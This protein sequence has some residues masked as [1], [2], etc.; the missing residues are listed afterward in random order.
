MSK[1]CDE[2]SSHHYLWP[3]SAYKEDQKEVRSTEKSPCPHEAPLGLDPRR[4]GTSSVPY[5]HTRV[6]EPSKTQVHLTEKTHTLSWIMKK[7]VF[8]MTFH[9]MTQPLSFLWCPHGL[10]KTHSFIKGDRITSQVCTDKPEKHPGM[11]C[12]MRRCFRKWDILELSVESVQ[13][14]GGLYTE[15]HGTISLVWFQEVRRHMRGPAHYKMAA[16]RACVW[17]AE[18][19]WELKKRTRCI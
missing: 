6:L 10:T 15:P 2:D 7:I 9:S 3:C 12:E 11:A 14:L 13:E 1:I 19:V 5:T 18:P 16:Y 17:L 4:V 8:E